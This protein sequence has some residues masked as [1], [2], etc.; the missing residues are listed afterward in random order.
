[1]EE[2]KVG[3]TWEERRE[4][5]KKRKRDLFL[6]VSL[7]CFEERGFNNTRISDI[8][9]KAGASVGSFYFYFDNKDDLL[10]GILMKFYELFMY[11]LNKLNKKELPSISEIREVL[12]EYAEMF[13]ERK[14]TGMIYIEQM[15]GISKKFGAMKNQFIENWC[16]ELEKI[17]IKYIKNKNESDE[18]TLLISRMWLGAL[19]ELV[20]WWILTEFR[21]SANRLTEIAVNFL[22]SSII[23]FNK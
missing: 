7:E 21:M 11:K 18:E 15:G 9:E 12:K 8:A 1:M 6:I 5:I 22:M 10:E 14:N 19:L 17:I 4:K 16:I 23:G 13:K 3:L 2:R 20:H